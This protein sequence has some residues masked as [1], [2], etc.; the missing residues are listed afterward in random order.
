MKEQY[1]TDQR[2]YF[3]YSILRHLLEQGTRCT[4]CWMLTPDDGGQAGRLRDYVEDA[5][6][7]RNL[8]PDV[9]DFL[10]GQML[11]GPPV[12]RSIE[13][14]NSPI[15]ECHFHWDPFPAQEGQR[16]AY[17][18]NCIA[19]ARDSQLIFVDPDTGPIPARRPRATTIRKYIEWQEIAHIY[20]RGFSVLIYHSLGRIPAKRARQVMDTRNRL[21]RTL[22]DAAVHAL[23]T[24]D[25]AFYFA[26]QGDHNR[27][28]QLAIE[29]IIEDWMGPLLRRA[30]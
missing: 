22:P 29:N 13:Q 28:V 18:N 30:P 25:D 27:Q 17:F 20:N 15:A 3:K 1:F 9:F 2:D 4:V 12:M 11:P 24:N 7:W 10:R 14:P 26:V 23:R 8:D 19:A 16:L 6:N 5:A 21:Q